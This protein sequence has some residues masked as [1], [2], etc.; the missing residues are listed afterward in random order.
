[1]DHEQIHNTIADFD[2]KKVYPF[3]LHRIS[4]L[5]ALTGDDRLC[6]E[7]KELLLL[8]FC[9]GS[10][11]S[12]DFL[13]PFSFMDLKQIANLIL[14]TLNTNKM[15]YGEVKISSMGELRYLLKKSF[16]VEERFSILSS[17]MQNR[18]TLNGKV[19]NITALGSFVHPHI[20]H[21][22]LMNL[23]LK[24]ATEMNLPNPQVLVWTQYNHIRRKD[25]LNSYEKRISQLTKAFS[26]RNDINVMN[27]PGDNFQDYNSVIA[28]LLA[29]I[30]G[31][32]YWLWGSDNLIKFIEPA[33]AGGSHW[34]IFSNPKIEIMISKRSDDK[35]ED[36]ELA[37]E[38]FEKYFHKK[39]IRLPD[40]GKKEGIHLSSSF[41]K[42]LSPLDPRYKKLSLI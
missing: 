10:T 38:R 22:E 33:I 6:S 37:S 30:N 24:K 39:I 2:E 19:T 4:L 11:R 1:M 9:K 36:L 15:Q 25:F 16:A 12:L 27:I 8:E 29:G 21:L 42:N 14:K 5:R 17:I 26:Q 34:G 41:M 32:L 28:D 40:R 3:P 7:I 13:F 31:K 20:S 35:T 23:A 18:S